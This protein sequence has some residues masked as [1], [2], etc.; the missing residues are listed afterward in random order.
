MNPDPWLTIVASMVSGIVGV[1][2]GAVLTVRRQEQVERRLNQSAARIT[3]FEL[4]ENASYLGTAINYSRA[5]PVLVRTWPETRARLAAFLVPRGT[6]GT[7]LPH[8]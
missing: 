3:Y 6:R 4:A 5:L 2:A 1:V 8:T 7:S